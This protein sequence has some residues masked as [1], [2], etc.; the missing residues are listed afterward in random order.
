[1]QQRTPLILAL[2]AALVVLSQ[3]L[4][5]GPALAD[6]LGD[7]KAGLAALDRGDSAAAVPLFTRA[8]NG[9]GLK[10]AD[11]ELAFVMRAKAYL[12][13]GQPDA[14]LADAKRALALA[15]DD[16]EAAQIRDAA[17]AARAESV[18]RAAATPDP[19]AAL[20]GRITSQNAEV[21]ARNH[22]AQAQFDQQ[23]QAYEAAKRTYE[24]QVA[25]Q[26]A[27]VAQ[28]QAQAEEAARKHA[29]D[30]A[31]WQARVKACQGGDT[32]QCGK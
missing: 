6:A 11:R 15:P 27:Q 12:G 5:A 13:Q 19:S 18:A 32:T 1:M 8:L 24:A 2:S 14:A 10:G 25:Q 28:Q 22:A 23:Q 26:R 31:A 3:G 9:K 29:A 20:N 30:L 4:L 21:D 17:E 16:A 7:A